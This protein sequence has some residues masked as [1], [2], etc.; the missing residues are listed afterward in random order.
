L[1]ESRHPIDTARPPTEF[2]TPLVGCCDK[3]SPA[4]TRKR[5]GGG[6]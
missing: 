5:A 4:N 6:G 2:Q 3:S 1:S